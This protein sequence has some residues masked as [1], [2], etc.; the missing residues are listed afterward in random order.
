MVTAGARGVRRCPTQARCPSCGGALAAVAAVCPACGFAVRA[1]APRRVAAPGVALSA[2]FA[3]S[4]GA[5]DGGGDG[6]AGGWA[7]SAPSP[8]RRVSAPSAVSAPPSQVSV[9]VLATRWSGRFTTRA[10]R[11][12]TTTASLG[13]PVA[14]ASPGRPRVTPGGDTAGRHVGSAV[15]SA[16]SASRGAVLAAAGSVG[17]GPGPAT[18]ASPSARAVAEPITVAAARARER[19]R[20]L[21]RVLNGRPMAG[22]GPAEGFDQVLGSDFHIDSAISGADPRDRGPIMPPPRSPRSGAAPLGVAAPF[23]AP[24]GSAP[25]PPGSP[26]WHDTV[27]VPPPPWAARRR[28]SAPRGLR[29]AAIAA[30]LVIAAVGLVAFRSGVTPSADVGGPTI[31][32]QATPSGAPTAAQLAVVRARLHALAAIVPSPAG[33]IAAAR[34]T[35]AARAHMLWVALITWRDS[36]SLSAHQLR[37]LDNAVAYAGT[38][39]RWLG[40]PHSAA[41]HAA[42]VKA[43]RRWR[44]DDPSL[45]DP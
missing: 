33:Q 36:A 6:G 23:A 32:V 21:R 31:D 5:V 1:A 19:G 38:L 45:G 20:E 35:A 30:V 18:G 2:L 34:P 25:P 9:D 13:I 37:V 22:G 7:P 42:T 8:P 27:A 29:L 10:A 17:G 40:A 28:A 15:G 24:P 39:S 11:S 44:A 16:G 4:D 41:R 3:S 43:W 14:A 12:T 26:W